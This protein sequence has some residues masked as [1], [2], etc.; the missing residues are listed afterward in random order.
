MAK[1]NVDEYI[2]HIGFLSI[3]N[4]TVKLDIEE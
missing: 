3:R 1:F 2:L 4:S